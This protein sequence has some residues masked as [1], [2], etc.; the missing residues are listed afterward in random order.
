M[1]K[2]I[3]RYDPNVALPESGNIRDIPKWCSQKSVWVPFVV[4]L[5]ISVW[6]TLKAVLDK[7][8]AKELHFQKSPA[9]EVDKEQRVRQSKYLPKLRP[10][11]QVFVYS[12]LGFWYMYPLSLDYVIDFFHIIRGSGQ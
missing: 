4:S 9:V 2:F 10:K 11:T 7:D 3:E 8:S 1:L 5:D 6:E 12:M